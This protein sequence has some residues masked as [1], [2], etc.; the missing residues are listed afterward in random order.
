[1]EQVATITGTF[2]PGAPDWHYLPVEIPE[3]VREIEVVYRYDKPDVPPGVRGNALDIGVF[4]PHEQFRGWSGGARDRFTINATEATPGYL[5]GPLQPGEWQILLAPYT[6]SPQGMAFEVDVTVRFGPDGPAFRPNP[7]P[8]TAPAADRGRSWYRGD[9]HVHTIYSDGRRKPGE[10]VADARKAGL[11]F[12]VSTE[13]NTS[14]AHL[15]WGD[16]A[17]EDLLILN[18][19]EVTTRTGHWPAWNLPAGT[20]IDWRYRADDPQRLRKFVDE[21]HESGGMVVAAHPFGP[22][23]GCTWEFGYERADLVEVWNGPWTLDD[24]ATVIAWDSLLRAGRWIPAVGNSD[25]HTHN[26]QV[27]LPHNVVL[28]DGLTGPQLMEGFA[29]GRNWIAESSAVQLEFTA[30][31][32]DTTVGIGETLRTDPGTPIALEIKASGAPDTHVRILDQHGPQWGGYVPAA[33][34]TVTWTTQS[35][36]SKWVRVEIRREQPTSTT[37]DTMVALTNPIFFR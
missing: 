24:E 22:C 6:V 8:S 13:H 10:L 31:A 15:Q 19:E 4:G 17:T 5:A 30:T 14:S 23:V 20:W 33:G 27:G 37:R 7:A 25:S 18:G 34:A 2:G 32:D 35:R 3:G 26:D 12:I 36:Y 21:V 28:A 16:H 11:D 9:G 1:M 29:K